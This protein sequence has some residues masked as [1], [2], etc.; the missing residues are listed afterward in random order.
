MD[1]EVRGQSVCIQ[2]EIDVRKC[3]RNMTGREENSSDTQ[4]FC[5]NVHHHR[6]TLRGLVGCAADPHA[7]LQQHRDAIHLVNFGTH[8]PVNCHA[9]MVRGA[10]RERAADHLMHIGFKQG[11][12]TH[13]EQFFI[14][15]GQDRL[16][17]VGT[18]DGA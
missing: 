2:P 10:D 14:G 7:G 6:H 17:T 15:G 3:F 4:N 11:E 9:W 12:T 8:S 18:E 1:G 16:P 13:Y 5:L